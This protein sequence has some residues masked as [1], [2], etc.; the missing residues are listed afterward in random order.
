MDFAVLV[1]CWVKIK[2]SKMRDKYLNLARELKLWNIKVMVIPFVVGTLRTLPKG[3]VKGLEELEIKHVQII[4]TTM[5]IRI[6]R[7]VLMT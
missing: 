5:L 4:Q 2:E 6:L 1:D 7:K 3:L